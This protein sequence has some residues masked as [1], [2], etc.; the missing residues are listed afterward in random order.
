MLPIHYWHLL[1]FHELLLPIFFIQVN[2]DWPGRLLRFSLLAHNKTLFHWQQAVHLI[3]HEQHTSVSGP[4]FHNLGPR[5]RRSAAHTQ[6]HISWLTAHWALH[7]GHTL[8][9]TVQRA[10]YLCSSLRMWTLNA[11]PV[12][13]AGSVSGGRASWDGSQMLNSVN[14]FWSVFTWNDGTKEVRVQ[15]HQNPILTLANYWIHNVYIHSRL[16]TGTIASTVWASVFC[17]RMSMK[18]MTC[19]VLPNPILWA[20]MQPKPLLVLYRSRDSMRL[21]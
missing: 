5:Q 10:T 16:L 14:Q 21:S 17:R 15:F 12:M 3:T 8:S 4:V 6:T 11:R 19:S 13:N 20:R 1:T 2:D 18:E 7:P 9:H